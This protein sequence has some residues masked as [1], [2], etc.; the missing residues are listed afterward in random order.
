MAA[1][2]RHML[3]M[4][5][6]TSG[7]HACTGEW[8]SGICG[9]HDAAVSLPLNSGLEIRNGFISDNFDLVR[10]QSPGSV[11]LSSP[12]MQSLAR[13]SSSKRPAPTARPVRV[14]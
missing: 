8:T 6:V 4:G 3:R 10:P 7:V 13:A 1:G 12:R 11:R 5:C 9:R 14:A 2:T